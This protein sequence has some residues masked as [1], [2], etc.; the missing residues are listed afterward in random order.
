MICDCT[1]QSVRRRSAGDAR[2][3]RISFLLPPPPL[4]AT[5]PRS[6]RFILSIHPSHSFSSG[7]CREV[8]VVDLASTPP[9]AADFSGPDGPYSASFSVLAP[10]CRPSAISCASPPPAM[11]AL[12]DLDDDDDLLDD[13]MP[14]PPEPGPPPAAYSSPEQLRSG[15]PPPSVCP[16]VSTPSPALAVIASSSAPAS[17]ECSSYHTLGVSPSS[18]ATSSSPT[19]TPPS[20]ELSPRTRLR[21]SLTAGGAPL[22][23]RHS[24]PHQR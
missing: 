15:A 5:D 21:F 9:A 19:G 17:G 1:Q 7:L 18:M 4:P 22:E 12:V 20:V 10:S 8:K 6:P 16:L 14:R 23:R 11:P 2:R 13:D 24:V 3:Q